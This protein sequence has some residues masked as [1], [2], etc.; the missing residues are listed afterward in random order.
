MSEDLWAGYKHGGEFKRSLFPCVSWYS[1]PPPP[2]STRRFWPHSGRFIARYKSISFHSN[3]APSALPFQFLSP[4]PHSL[5]DTCCGPHVTNHNT[6]KHTT[7]EENKQPGSNKYMFTR[8]QCTALLLLIKCLGP[9]ACCCDSNVLKEKHCSLL[10]KQ[11]N[12]LS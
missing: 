10:R 4:Y 6:H 1:H 8:C 12:E 3:P 5:P 9:A 7:K 2:T 11:N